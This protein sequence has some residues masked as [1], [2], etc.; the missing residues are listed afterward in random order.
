MLLVMMLMDLDIGAMHRRT[1]VIVVMYHRHVTMMRAIVAR[2]PVFAL[3]MV[4]MA[5]RLVSLIPV[6]SM[7]ATLLV[8]SRL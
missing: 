7:K 6:L 4:T 8:G 2:P 5:I 3:C 1:R